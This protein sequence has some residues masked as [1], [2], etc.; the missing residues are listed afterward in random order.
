MY[1]VAS[2]CP[3]RPMFYELLRCLLDNAVNR[4][5][6]AQEEH[7]VCCA[8]GRANWRAPPR[9]AR[10]PAKVCASLLPCVYMYIY[11]YI[12]YDMY[13]YICMYVCIYI[14]IYI[15]VYMYI[16][17]YIIINMYSIYIYIYIYVYIYIYTHSCILYQL[18]IHI[19]C[20]CI[21]IYI[22]IYIH[23]IPGP[24]CGKAELRLF[25]LLRCSN[26]IFWRS[27]G[28]ILEERAKQ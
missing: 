4:M 24:W 13:I 14:Y 16:Y 27:S 22:Y 9:Q 20:I 19:L 1:R 23:V 5:T 11:I 26:S 12:W 18:N 6:C 3:G 8:G 21:Y 10:A 25:P 2:R 7:T 15:Y 28:E 17:I